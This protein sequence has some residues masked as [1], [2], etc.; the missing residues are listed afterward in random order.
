[1]LEA[2]PLTPI[3]TGDWI[4][5]KLGDYES[6]SHFGS[7]KITTT[8]KFQPKWSIPAKVIEVRDLQLKVQLLG[9]P[10]EICRLIP[11]SQV[12]RLPCEIPAS[13]AQLHMKNIEIEMPR[14]PV[15]HRRKIVNP[16]ISIRD[17]MSTATYGHGLQ[18]KK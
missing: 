8:K 4:Q 17:I 2:D 15:D 14:I 13:L 18:T 12:R 16:N 6:D 5:F 3:I 9:K 10:D 1:M 7:A 11:I